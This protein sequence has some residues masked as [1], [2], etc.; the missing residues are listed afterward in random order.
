M[1]STPLGPSRALALGFGHPSIG[2]PCLQVLEGVPE[3]LLLEVLRRAPSSLEELLPRLPQ[4]LTSLAALAHVPSLLTVCEAAPEC[5]EHG[6]C[7]D[8]TT[9][10]LCVD[11]SPAV[12]V[13]LAADSDDEH[14]EAADSE[15]A[16]RMWLLRG[17]EVPNGALCPEV[18]SLR[19]RPGVVVCRL[20]ATVSKLQGATLRLPDRS[21]LLL[22]PGALQLKDVKFK[23]ATTV[24][25]TGCCQ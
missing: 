22:G 23:G 11:T 3:R 17:D 16:A 19:R 5:A 7:E 24:T 10:T 8:C 18:F 12:P 1:N 14:D 15:A 13:G 21:C 9:L 20:T 6:A 4:C 25:C 2:S